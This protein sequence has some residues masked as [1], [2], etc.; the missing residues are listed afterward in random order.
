MGFNLRLLRDEIALRAETTIRYFIL[1]LLYFDI[2]TTTSPLA[3]EMQPEVLGSFGKALDKIH[4]N[5]VDFGWIRR[6]VTDDTLS[7]SWLCPSMVP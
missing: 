5:I 3:F 2:V 6:R 1:E 4:R 7:S